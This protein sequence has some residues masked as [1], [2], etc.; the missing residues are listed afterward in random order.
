MANNE[1]GIPR[2]LDAE[3][4]YY[5]FYDN[6]FEWVEVYTYLLSIH[7]EFGNLPDENVNKINKNFFRSNN[8]DFYSRKLRFTSNKDEFKLIRQKFLLN[9]KYSEKK[10]ILFD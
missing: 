4:K 2:L 10:I 3:G 8:N 7:Q 5:N 9:L 6:V 1:L